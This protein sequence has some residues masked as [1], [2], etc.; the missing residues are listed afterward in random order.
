MRE[1]LAQGLTASEVWRL[2]EQS[3][4]PASLWPSLFVPSQ[5][6]P[7]NLQSVKVLTQGRCRLGIEMIDSLGKPGLIF[8]GGGQQRI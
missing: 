2:Y 3:R 1:A 4:T 8:M 6:F 5:Q 7:V